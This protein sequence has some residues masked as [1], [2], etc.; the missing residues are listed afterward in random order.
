MA[1]VCVVFLRIPAQSQNDIS[2]PSCS[3]S[4]LPLPPP[5][6]PS[7]LLQDVVVDWQSAAHDVIISLGELCA[8]VVLDQLLGKF[9]ANV[10]PHY[11]VVKTLADFAQKTRLPPPHCVTA[12]CGTLA[13]GVRGEGSEGFLSWVSRRE[14]GVWSLRFV[15]CS[16]LSFFTPLLAPSPLSCAAAACAANFLVP[17]LKEVL[18]RMLP[19][20]GTIKHDNMRW[21][22]AAGRLAGRHPDPR[23]VELH[24]PSLAA[25]MFAC[26]PPLLLVC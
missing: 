12:P 23:W 11:F 15:G 5:L 1:F 6:L 7:C 24:N 20:I 17:R 25:P 8:P 22:F 19:L 21:V 3:S 16:H 10:L 14:L 2:S 18:M 26:N 13:A 9:E 4:H